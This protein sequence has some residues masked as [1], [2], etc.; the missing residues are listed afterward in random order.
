MVQGTATVQLDDKK[1]TLEVGEAIDIPLGAHHALGN[2]TDEPVIVIEV[3]M[4]SY[5]GEDDIVRVSDP[6]G[7]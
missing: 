1:L 7:R 2:D 3:Q 6:Y 5:F 4:G